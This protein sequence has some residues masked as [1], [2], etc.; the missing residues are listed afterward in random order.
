LPKTLKSGG[1]GLVSM[2]ER[3]MA[4]GGDFSILNNGEH[5]ATVQVVVPLSV[6]ASLEGVL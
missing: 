6:V 2:R 1:I 3:V 4:F 5:G